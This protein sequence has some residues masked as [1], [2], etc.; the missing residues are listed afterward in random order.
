MPFSRRQGPEA[1]VRSS[2]PSMA[3]RSAAHRHIVLIGPMGSGKTRV[4]IEVARGLGRPMLDTDEAI[5]SEYGVDGARIAEREGVETLHAIELAVAHRLA[6][7]EPASVIACAES[8]VDT[9]EGWSLLAAH[10]AVWLDAD[11]LELARRRSESRHRRPIDEAEATRLRERRRIHLGDACE[12]RFDTT[13]A[14]PADVA[15]E[16]VAA[17]GASL[18]ASDAARAQGGR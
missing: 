5:R 12:A 17:M 7:T 11:A 15:E 16:I 18:D 1:A 2:V 3:H 13:N 9:P 14:D 8:V 4:G 6:A 10:R